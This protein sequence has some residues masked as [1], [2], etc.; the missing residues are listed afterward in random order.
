MLMRVSA[1]QE[2]HDASAIA[3]LVLMLVLILVLMH[4]IRLSK[5][6]IYANGERVLHQHSLLPVN[7]SLAYWYR[8]FVQLLAVILSVS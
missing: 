2:G 8:P 7:C 5:S 1:F 4:V 3:M 6:L